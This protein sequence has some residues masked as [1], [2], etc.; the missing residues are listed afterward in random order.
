MKKIKISSHTLLLLII[1]ISV[2]LPAISKSFKALPFED[3]LFF[4]TKRYLSNNILSLGKTKNALW[5]GT[6][7][8]CCRYDG[9]TW[10]T[11]SGNKLVPDSSKLFT[12]IPG[13]V[14]E[15]TRNEINGFT[16][17]RD[18]L[19]IATDGGLIRFNLSSARWL[20]FN[21]GNSA[22]SS[23]YIQSVY[24]YKDLIFAGTWGNSLMVYNRKKTSFDLDPGTNFKGTF[25]T[26]ITGDSKRILAGTLKKGINIFNINLNKWKNISLSSGIIPSNKVT[27]IACSKDRYFIGTNKG[28]TVLDIKKDKNRLYTTVNCNIASDSIK[29]LLFDNKSGLL[30]AGT[31][32]GLSVFNGV[33]W[34]TYTI[35]DGLPENWITSL[36]IWNNKLWVGTYANGVAFMDL[37]PDKK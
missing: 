24:A 29:A 2:C 9:L 30:Y 31:T 27:S 19:W 12:S 3:G 18:N 23:N 17:D 11:F 20:A 26:S 10:K 15:F 13:N 16:S 4:K 21:K 37:T 14:K 34:K 35:A 7:W 36:V 6:T 28:L 5:I 33:T 1:C 32:R 22:V 8:G 25:I